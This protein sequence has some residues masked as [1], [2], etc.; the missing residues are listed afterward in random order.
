[1]LSLTK[2]ECIGYAFEQCI[3]NGIEISREDEGDE[4]KE[5]KEIVC[6]Y[7]MELEALDEGAEAYIKWEI[8]V[9]TR[10]AVKNAKRL[11]EAL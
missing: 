7:E 5:L 10:E 2:I 9:D 1:M 8:P 4:L 11:K 3:A 6:C